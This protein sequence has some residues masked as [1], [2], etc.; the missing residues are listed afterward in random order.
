MDTYIH[1]KPHCL[2]NP[3]L[4]TPRRK[5]RSSSP[6]AG[7]AAEREQL[8]GTAAGKDSP[9]VGFQ[10][11]SMRVCIYIYIY[12]TIIIYIYIY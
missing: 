5:A 10:P 8:Q 6:E 7:R 9:C 4:E 12:I 3:L 11:C 2:L 1:T